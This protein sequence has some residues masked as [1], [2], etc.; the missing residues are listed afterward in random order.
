MTYE[1]EFDPRALKEWHKLG[2]T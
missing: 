1:L 2:D